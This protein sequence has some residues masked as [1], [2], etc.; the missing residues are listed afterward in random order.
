MPVINNETVPKAN[1]VVDASEVMALRRVVQKCYDA[2]SFQSKIDRKG[3]LLRELL[4]TLERRRNFT[5]EQISHVVME[6][7][8]LTA[9]E[10]P[11][12][13]FQ[14]SYGQT[15]SAKALIAAIKDPTI[16]RVLSLASIIF[17]QPKVDLA[18]IDDGLIISRF[19]SFREGQRLWQEPF[20]QMRLLRSTPESPARATL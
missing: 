20:G 14:A 13:F 11:S 18:K 4:E 15:R 7:V 2:L 16:N 9:S 17:E 8:R 1:K 19:K 3:V 10:R 12:W 5:K 6:L